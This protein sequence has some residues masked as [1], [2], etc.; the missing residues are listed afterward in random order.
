MPALVVTAMLAISAVLGGGAY[1]ASTLY[2]QYGAPRTTQSEIDWAARPET[3]LA[4]DCRGCHTEAAA[5]SAGNAHATLLCESCHV[6]SIDHP[7]SAEGVTR[8]LPAAT[9]EQCIACHTSTAGKPAMFPQVPIDAHYVGAECVGCHEPHSSTAIEP[10]QVT[11]PLANLPDCSVCHSP[12]GLKQ[13][14]A[15][16]QIAPDATCLA[17]HRPGAAGIPLQ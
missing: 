4:S 16:H 5:E 10:R 14:P 3:Y 2:G 17:C 13:F 7:G 12:A 9:S 11:H 6:P 1:A 15:N 8:M